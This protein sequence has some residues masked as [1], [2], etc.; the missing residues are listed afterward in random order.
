MKKLVFGLG[1]SLMGLFASAQNGLENIIVEKYYV[2]NAADATVNDGISATPGSL[3]VGSVTYRVYADMLPGYK[4]QAVY[5]TLAHTLRIQASTT[6]FNNEDRGAVTGNAI[7][8]TFLRT[9]TVGLDSYLSVGAAA[10]GNNYGI[11]KPLDNAVASLL[12]LASN[13]A[14]K[15]VDPTAGLALTSRDGIIAGPVAPEAVT[16]VGLSSGVANE[17]DIFDNTIAGG[18]FQTTNGSIAALAG[19]SGPVLADNRVLIGQFTT[20]GTFT[21]E[22]NIQVGT[23]TGGTQQFV[24]NNPVGA[25]ISIPSLTLTAPNAAPVATVTSPANGASFLAGAS[26]ALTATATD[27][28][29]TVASVEF[30]VD[31]VSVGVDATSP[32]TATYTAVAGPRVITARATDNLAL[33]GP[34][35]TPVNITVTTPA[36][37][38]PVTTLTSPAAGSVLVGSSIAIAATATDADGTV[39]SVEFFVNGVSVGIDATAPYTA[40]ATA[41]VG[42][43]SVTARATDNLAL[44]GASTAAVVVTGV[45]NALPVVSITAPTAAASITAPAV[46]AISANAVDPDGTIASVD[47]RVNGVSVGVDATAPYSVN[48]TS[49]IGAANITAIATDNNGGVT[50]SSIL[51]IVVADPNALP[52]KVATLKNNCVSPSFCLPVVAVDSVKTVIGY[53]LV[54]AYD[55][56]KITPTGVINKTAGLYNVA[57][58]DIINSIDAANG[59]INISVFFNGSAPANAVFFGKGE[60]FCVEFTKTPAFTSVDTAVVTIPSLQESF[61]TNVLNKVVEGGKY[62]T[63]KDSIFNGNL[64]FWSNN[65][66]IKYD[67]INPTANLITNIFGTNAACGAKSTTAVQ[68]NLTGNFVYNAN[69]GVNLSIEK[70]IVGTTDVQPVIN[71]AD[72]FLARRVLLNDASFLPSVYQIIAMDVN[73]DGVVSAGDVS[74]INLR[75]VLKQP[76]FK[77][78]GNAGKDWL[79]VDLARVS[80]NN[81]YKISTTYPSNDLIGYSKSR[82]PQVP[83]CLPV[84]VTNAAICPVF[85]PETYQGILLGD[86]NGN[87]ATASPNNLFRTVSNDRVIFDFSKAIVKD[88]MVDVPVAISSTSNVNALDLAIELKNTNLT[89]NSIVKHTAN[90]QSEAFFNADDNKLRFTSNSLQNYELNKSIISV[91]FDLNGGNFNEADLASINA[92]VNG[93]QAAL[94]VIGSASTAASVVNSIEVYPNPSNGLVNVSVSEDATVQVLDLNGKLVVFQSNVKANEK[95]EINVSALSNGVYVI[96]ISNDNFVSTKKLVIKK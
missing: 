28:N 3:P 29:G 65:S 63:F 37:A 83:F 71:G 24:A 45:T 8:S 15:N 70:D 44:V 13:P 18:L 43:N 74:Q 59:L 80:A 7:G 50:T 5:G 90:L 11:E 62:V 47:F 89:F 17:L 6:F 66:P 79:F 69:N 22:L 35:S 9:N 54:M 72:A 4:L 60:I 1:L 38:A 27:A 25:E 96:K 51:S 82:V 77:Q 95:S 84:P 48:W 73:L 85:T 39:A 94:R 46:V 52:Y 87:F 56:N 61:T 21:F 20:D 26:V 49:V 86:V 93:D 23:P 34:A 40:T 10:G 64:Q 67:P 55:K 78:A 91:R 16:F 19:A 32:Y 57:N 92:Y 41:I 31:G 81:A 68:P 36:N 75:T 12:N 2:S 42:A 14:M 58:V 33:V 53:D 76:D 88:G 30:F